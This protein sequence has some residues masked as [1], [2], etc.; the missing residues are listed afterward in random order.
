MIA[1]PSRQDP[2]APRL[3]QRQVY[4]QSG[5]APEPCEPR[6]A[7]R[8]DRGQAAYVHLESHTERLTFERPFGY[9]DPHLKSYPDK[10]L[11][12]PFG[13]E[14]NGTHSRY[15]SLD[16]DLAAHLSDT[17]CMDQHPSWYSQTIGLD[18]ILPN[19]NHRVAYLPNLMGA[20]LL[21]L[22]QGPSAHPTA[23]ERHHMP[24][25]KKP[26]TKTPPP[27][28]PFVPRAHN[29]ASSRRPKKFQRK[30]KKNKQ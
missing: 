15:N 12:S 27:Q 29:Q 21:H 3:P 4:H 22:A 30:K 8:R 5:A 13:N 20:L 10:L 14:D 6:A 16:T 18:K 26:S 25:S 2:R 11:A 17:C 19:T 23:P 28:L 1:D 9:D 7:L 24:C